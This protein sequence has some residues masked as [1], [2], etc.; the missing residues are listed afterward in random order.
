MNASQ[1]GAAEATPLTVN[2]DDGSKA[3]LLEGCQR[4]R[5]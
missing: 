4:G 2:L 3:L 5:R 1:L